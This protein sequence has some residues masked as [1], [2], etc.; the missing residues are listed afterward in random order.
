MEQ[1]GRV[2]W[3][4]GGITTWA[5]CLAVER[6]GSC[7]RYKAGRVDSTTGANRGNRRDPAESHSNFKEK[8]RLIFLPNY[9]CL[10]SLSGQSR[11]PTG[12]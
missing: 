11:M 3:P 10:E 7:P 2:A 5:E 1:K 8:S 6:S 9:G 4:V 12:L